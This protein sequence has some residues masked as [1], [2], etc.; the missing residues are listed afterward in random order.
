MDANHKKA[1]LQRIDEELS[2]LDET[3][4]ELEQTTAP[5]EPDASIGRLSRL[6][7]MINQGVAKQSLDASKLRMNKLRQ[8]KV[9]LDEDPFF[10]ECAECGELIA[11]ARLLAM[12]ETELCVHC[13]E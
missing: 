7:N 10:G 12:P 3:V 4:K 2:A 11:P 1:L 6:D 8:A 5:V 9:R 13:A